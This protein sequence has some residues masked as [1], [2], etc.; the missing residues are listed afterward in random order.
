MPSLE[1]PDGVKIHWEEKGSGPLVVLAPYA[2]AYPAVYDPLEANLVRDHRVVRYDDRGSG[3]S[4]HAG[5]YDME[6]GAGDLEAVLEQVGAPAVVIALGD[7]V[8]RAARV[9]ARRPDLVDALVVP[10][11]NPAGRKRLRDSDV[12]VTSDSVLDAFLSMGATDYR[13]AL[14]SAVTAGNPQMREDEVRERVSRQVEYQPQEIAVAR[15]RAWAEDDATDAGRACGDRLWLLY[16]EDTTGG[17]F[18]AGEEGRRIARR[19]FPEAHVVEVEDG[20]ISR[21]DLTGACVRRVTSKARS[22]SI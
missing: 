8:H 22:A 16:S 17:W 5:P 15:W 11:G 18:P 10:G 14:R 1:R 3:A 19:L 4:D 12:L 7:A 9:A 13:G 6:T 21:P 2:V 20:M